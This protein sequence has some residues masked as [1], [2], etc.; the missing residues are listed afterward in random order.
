[1]KKENK[2]DLSLTEHTENAEFYILFF[3]VNYETA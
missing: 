2:I 3:A 1:M